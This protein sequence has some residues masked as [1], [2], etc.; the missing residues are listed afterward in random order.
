[1]KREGWYERQEMRNTYGRISILD[2]RVPTRLATQRAGLVEEKVEFGD[3]S[4]FGEGGDER[5]SL[6]ASISVRWLT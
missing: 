2:E 3:G 5:M 4:A 1:M 6:I